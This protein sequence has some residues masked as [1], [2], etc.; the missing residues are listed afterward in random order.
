[1]MIVS[2]IPVSV[3][4]FFIGLS[5]LYGIVGV[6]LGCFAFLLSSNEVADVADYLANISTTLENLLGTDKQFRIAPKGKEGHL[7]LDSSRRTM[8][9]AEMP[10]SWT[11]RTGGALL[12]RS[13]SQLELLDSS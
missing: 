13:S 11:Q 6:V 5:L 1:M 8:P 7:Y 9:P 3:C 4:W 12:S 10:A 2:R